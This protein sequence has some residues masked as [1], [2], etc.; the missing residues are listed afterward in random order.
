M[1]SQKVVGTHIC[2]NLF[3]QNNNVKNRFF[4]FSNTAF[5]RQKG[6]GA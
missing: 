5:V 3:T 2:L 6:I 1:G 4:H